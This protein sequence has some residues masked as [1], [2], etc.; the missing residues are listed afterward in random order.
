MV[1]HVRTSPEVK[2]YF[3]KLWLR[4]KQADTATDQ[5]DVLLMALKALEKELDGK[6]E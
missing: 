6:G 4:I 1:F 2:A 3:V 5:G